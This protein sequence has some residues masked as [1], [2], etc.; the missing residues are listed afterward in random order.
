MKPFIW[1]LFAVTLLILGFG[2]NTLLKA[3]PPDRVARINYLSGS[4]SFERG[5]L[6]EWVTAVVNYPLISGDKIWT[7]FQS[8]AEMHVGQTAIR[9]SENTAL[10]F[11]NLDNQTIQASLLEGSID[12][13]IRKL[14]EDEFF[15]ID[16]PNVAISILR[17]GEY[18]IDVSLN[19]DT[20]VIARHGEVEINSSGSAF[21]I[22]SAEEARI[23]GLDDLTYDVLA[24]PPLDD[25]DRWSVQRNRLEDQLTSTK[26]VSRDIIGYEDLDQYGAWQTLPGYGNAWRPTS[27]PNGWAPYRYGHWVWIEPWGWTWID[28]TPWGFAPFHYGRWAYVNNT[29]YWVPGRIETRP[30]YAPALVAFVGGNNFN[31]SL[32]FGG[33]GV[34]WFPLAPGEVYVPAYHASPTYVRNVNVSHVTNITNVNVTN[35]NVTKV[36]YINQ[37]VPGSIT[38]VPQTTFT[39]GAKINKAVVSVPPQAVTA[40]AV[41]GTTASIAPTKQSLVP[42]QTAGATAKPT[43]HPPTNIQ[44]RPVT[45]KITPPAPPVSFTLKEKALT[46]S[47]GK[48]LDEKTLANIRQTAPIAKN[49]NPP[50]VVKPIDPNSN[51]VNKLHPA[52]EALTTT[53]PVNNIPVQA[54]KPNLTTAAKPN[55]E[56]KPTPKPQSTTKPNTQTDKLGVEKKPNQAVPPKPTP[57]PKPLEN[58]AVK[59]APKTNQKTIESEKIKEEKIKEEKAME[60]RHEKQEEKAEKL[61]SKPAPKPNQQHKIAPKPKPN[62]ENETPKKEEEKEPK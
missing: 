2:S 24:A 9:L 61:E 20:R 44:Q 54:A 46:S 31:L 25:F 43:V 50:P 14:G 12:V 17:P 22:R 60:E 4:V 16:T 56:A 7:D 23:S 57:T 21:S 5:D 59:A 45:A 30:V 42:Q 62:S 55:A 40:S 58:K 18:R 1:R 28:D 47:A 10:S 39:S 53:H 49:Q 27:V 33:G 51:T 52:R 13:H 11:L 19:G 38:A 48:P 35:V 6:D 41:I 26:Y 3:D 15:E 29:W 37:T 36:K 32:S 34:A 8:R